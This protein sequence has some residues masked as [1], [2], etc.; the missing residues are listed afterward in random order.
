MRHHAGFTM[1]ELLVAMTVLLLVLVAVLGVYSQ[2]ARLDS[3]IRATANIQ[4]N[5]RLGM[6]RVERDLRMIGFGVP[7]GTNIFNGTS[8]SPVIFHADPTT[9]GF[10]GEVDGGNAEI[11]CTPNPINLGCPPSRLVLDRVDYYAAFNCAPPDGSNGR[12]NLVAVNEEGSWQDLECTGVDTTNSYI[13]LFAG[14][15]GDTFRAGVSEARTI[16]Q[17]YLRYVRR[18][19]P[20]Y[21]YLTRSIRYDNQP[22]STF[23]PVSATWSVIAGQLTDFWLDYRDDSGAVISGS[24]LTAAQRAAVRKI[25]VSMEG[26]DSLVGVGGQPQLIQMRSEILVRNAGV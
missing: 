17:V 7:G 16:E 3:Y 24:P 14:V 23:P 25:V 26:Y 1:V 22:D 19:Q 20:P 5:V 21:G 18:P 9:I 6:D 10:R 8:W 4:D 12:M 2:A 15:P 13:S 11:I